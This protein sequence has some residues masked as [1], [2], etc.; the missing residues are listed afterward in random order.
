MA[1]SL[2]PE[3]VESFDEELAALLA[4]DF[5]QDPLSTPH[6]VFAALGRKD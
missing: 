6:K 5:P 1:A 3:E 2:E 4:A